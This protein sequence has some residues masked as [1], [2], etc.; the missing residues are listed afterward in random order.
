GLCLG[1]KPDARTDSSLAGRELACT[2]VEDLACNDLVNIL[3]G[4]TCTFQCGFDRVRT[5]IN[6][7]FRGEL[8][9]ELGEW[10]ASVSC[11]I[12]CHAITSSNSTENSAAVMSR[13]SSTVWPGASW[14]S[15]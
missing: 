4:N 14:R 2:T 10:G 3:G 7:T 12:G 1:I 9:G 6:G 8:A 15:T 11:N 5:Q 13:S